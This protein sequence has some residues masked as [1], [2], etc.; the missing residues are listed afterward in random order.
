MP[1]RFGSLS[2]L[3][4]RF[5][6]ALSP[7][8]PPRADEDWALDRLLAGEQALWRRMSGQDRRHAV[9]VARRAA[10][11]LERDA[12][13]ADRPVLAAALLHDVG[14]VEAGVGT[15]A[16]VAVTCAAVAV[17]PARLRGRARRYV[18]HDRIGGELLRAAGSDPLTIAWAEQ[19]HLAADRWTIDRRIGGLLRQADN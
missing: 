8:G 3:A 12:T 1:D 18:E 4:G 5:F 19:H 9:A 15:L 6:G 10:A 17:G 11:L 14:K 2:H 16:R 7:A 13:A